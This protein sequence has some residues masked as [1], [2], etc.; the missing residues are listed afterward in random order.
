M[1]RNTA[2]II[3]CV[4]CVFMCICVEIGVDISLLELLKMI[5][6]KVTIVFFLNDSVDSIFQPEFWLESINRRWFYRIL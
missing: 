3:L 2:Y 1:L 5:K 4:L 6:L